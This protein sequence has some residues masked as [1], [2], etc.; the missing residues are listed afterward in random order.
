MSELK[1]NVQTPTLI[2]FFPLCECGF[3]YLVSLE[4]I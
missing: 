2:S 3:D 1:E 4:S